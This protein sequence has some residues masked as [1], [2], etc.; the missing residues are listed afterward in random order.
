MVEANVAEEEEVNEPLQDYRKH[1][2]KPNRDSFSSYE[3][4]DG[5]FLMLYARLFGLY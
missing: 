3:A 4:I 5:V 2:M 1:H